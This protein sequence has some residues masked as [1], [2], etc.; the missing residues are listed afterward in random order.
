MWTIPWSF[1]IL[2]PIGKL[3]QLATRAPHELTQ[4]C[5]LKLSFRTVVLSDATQEWCTISWGDWDM[6]REMKWIVYNE[7][8][9][10]RLG[11][12]SK[13]LPKA[14]LAPKEVM[15][16]VQWSAGG[17]VQYSFRAW[18]K[19]MRM[20]Y[21]QLWW[22]MPRTVIPTAHTAQQRKF[23]SSG[24]CPNKQPMLQKWSWSVNICS[25]DMVPWPFAYLMSSSTLRTFFQRQYFHNCQRVRQIP[26]HGCL[27]Y[28]DKAN[29]PSWQ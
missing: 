21:A 23:S 6:L 22:A 19:P 28:R 17:L 26:Q 18:E 8:L 7:W 12:H 11:R 4:L 16:T 13:A 27:C 15:V 24:Q 2:K 9:R 3:K 25:F 14:K 10:D 20:N 29:I 1:G 5:P